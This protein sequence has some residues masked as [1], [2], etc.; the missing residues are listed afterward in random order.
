MIDVHHHL[1]PPAYAAEVA[2]HTTLFPQLRDWT[3]Q[4][5]ID[6]MDAG[7]VATAVLSMSTPGMWFGDAALAKRLARL[8]NEYA[9]RMR[10]DH[11]GRFGFFAALPAPDVDASLEEAAYAL[12][13]LKA[14]GVCLFTSY[15]TLYLGDAHFTPLLTELNRRKAVIYTHPTISPCC[16]N[17]VPQVSEA[18]IEYGTDT[19][20]AIASLVFSGAAAKFQDVRFIFS[21]AGGTMP[22]LIGR[23]QHH[24]KRMSAD[25]LPRGLMP[26]IER[27]FYD[28]AQACNPA[29]MAALRAVVRSSQVLFGTDFPWGSSKAH[30]EALAGCGFSERELAM[31]HSENAMRMNLD[32]SKAQIGV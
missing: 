18:T 23:F 31:I 2:R 16:V 21:H 29:A 24:A 9:A 11:P 28:T 20:R 22:F 6:D 8:C 3:P 12:D 1:C 15:G 4:R 27:F 25:T 7:G 14:D 5:S 10:Q 26:E 17:I 30:R 32:N 13:V 19:T